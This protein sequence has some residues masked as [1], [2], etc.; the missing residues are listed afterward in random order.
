MRSGNPKGKTRNSKSE[1]RNSRTWLG[2]IVALHLALGL[3]YW[4]HTA[5]GV[6]PDE[7]YHGVYVGH[8]VEKH[9]LP[10]FSAGDM[11]NYEAHQPPL[12]YALGVPFYLAAR[13]LGA[14]DPGVGVRLLSLILGAV[15]ILAAYATIRMLTGRESTA[16]AC[17]GFVAFLPMHLA[18]S[19]SVGNDILTELIFGVALLLMTKLLVEPPTRGIGAGLGLILGLGILTKTTCI[20]LFPAAILAYILL[21][22]RGTLT[23]TMAVRGMAVML[24]ISLAVG[25]WWLV[26][27]AM[28]CGDPLALAQ[29]NQAF[30]HT[31]TPDYFLVG[32][33]L[34]WTGYFVLVIA[35]T[36]ASCWGVFGHMKVFMPTWIYGILAI[37]SLVTLVGSVKSIVALKR[38]SVARRDA[39]IVLTAVGTLVLLSFIR[40]N[41]SF[42]QAQGR[43]LYPT[44]IPIALAFV[45]GVERFLPPGNRRWSAVVVNGG[46][47]LLT[48][49][50]LL[51]TVIPN[52][53]YQMP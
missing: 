13:A 38:E 22:K 47:L 33:G 27:N 8:L 7:A 26:R 42:F 45:L 25:G 52:L 24:G 30:A 6:A 41:L 23:T 53:P 14:E 18:L 51:T 50:A 36:F 37:V 34:T 19:N 29:F 12:Y 1:I 43:Y 15:S 10:V 11:E 32:Q 2:V 16:L 40:F 20:L 5:Y 39:L 49:A 28:L 31:P 9:S 4:G 48:I 17:A 44:I 3:I 46:M 21:W 35:W